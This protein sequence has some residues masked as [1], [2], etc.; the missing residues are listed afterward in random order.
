MQ[1]GLKGKR[2]SKRVTSYETLRNRRKKTVKKK[3]KKKKKTFIELNL[4]TRIS[5]SS[6]NTKK[7][8]R[9]HKE[10]IK[11]TKKNKENYR[12]KKKR[13]DNIR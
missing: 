4:Q 9:K 7:T 6:K 1:G 13:A 5:D 8:Q 11:K 10:N 12:K 2:V 3:K